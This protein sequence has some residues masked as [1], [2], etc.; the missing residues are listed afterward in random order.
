MAT[1]TDNETQLSQTLIEAFPSFDWSAGSAFYEQIIKPWAVNLT[2]RDVAIQLTKDNMS[3]VQVLNSPDPDSDHVDQLLSNFLITRRQGS[4][5]SGYV[6]VYFAGANSVTVSSQTT[7]TCAGVSFAPK[8]TYIGV[9]GTILEQST[10]EV[11]Y[12]QAVSLGNSEY[13]FAIE[14]DS[15]DNTDVILGPGQ[16]CTNDLSSNFISS[17]VTASTFSGGSIPETTSE[18]IERAQLGITTSSNTGKDNIRSLVEKSAY[19]VLDSQVFG[20]GDAVQLRDSHNNAGISSGGRADVYVSTDALIQKVITP[21]SA[22]RVSGT[23]WRAEIPADIYPGAYGVSSIRT[24]SYIIDTPIQHEISLYTNSSRPYVDTPTEARYSKYQTMSVLFYDANTL[25][26]AEDSKT[27]SFEILYMPNIADLQDY[28]E[29]DDIEA[30]LSDVLVKA[31][32]PIEVSTGITIDYAPGVLPPD[33]AELQVSVASAIN[34][35]RAGASMLSASDIVYAVKSLFP[36]GTVR[37]PIT[38]QG[39]TYLPDGT[40]RYSSD[41]DNIS[42]PSNVVGVTPGNTKFFSSPDIVS[43]SLNEGL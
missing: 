6:S 29:G 43:I 39:T 11:Q 37:M 27:Y 19:N 34:G 35:R 2:D 41:N 16:S 32:V 13:V 40:V 3:L 9:V 17:M 5:A 38:M 23:L 30:A 25:G 8:K 21:L 33:V 10:D 31:F 14:V 7:I 4:V 24:T 22:S 18:F 28:I 20:F 36:E 1:L 15:I 12:V 42:V 26:T